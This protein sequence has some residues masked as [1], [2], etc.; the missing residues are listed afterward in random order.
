MQ[1]LIQE[2]NLHYTCAKEPKMSIA[3]SKLNT[4]HY[5]LTLPIPIPG[6]EKKVS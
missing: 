5:K 1:V 2:Q 3:Y 6:E 4:L